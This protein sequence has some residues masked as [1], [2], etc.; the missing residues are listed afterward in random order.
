GGVGVAA[1]G[2]GGGGP[3]VDVAEGLVEVAQVAAEQAPG[4]AGELRQA[5]LR[6]AAQDQTPADVTV[7][8]HEL[9]FEVL[10]VAASFQLAVEFTA[11]WKLAP[12]FHCRPPP[13]AAPLP[14]PP[15]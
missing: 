1:G 12:V 15:R 2:G 10:T 8:R 7:G 11:S 3:A 14:A 4:A 9:S 5:L 13:P 6:L